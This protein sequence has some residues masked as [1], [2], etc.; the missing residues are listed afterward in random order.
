MITISNSVITA[1]ISEMGAELKSLR[2]DGFEYIW[3][4][5][6]QVWEDSA[7]VLFPIVGSLK[8]D[9]YKFEGREYKLTHHGFASKKEFSVKKKSDTAVTLLLC[10]DSETFKCYPFKFELRVTFTLKDT[11]LEICYKVKNRGKNTMYFSLG[12]HEAYATPE[13]VEDYDIIFDEKE[14][15]ETIL[16]NGGLL[17]DNK[18]LIA[19]NTNVM[20]LYDKYFIL[21]TL[22]FEGLKSKQCI[23]RNRKTER[24]VK[25][26]FPDSDYIAFWHYP[27]SSYLCIEPWSGLPDNQNSDYDITKKDGIITLKEAEEYRNIHKI[28]V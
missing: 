19:K 28:T 22:L 24:T 8:D 4:G 10:D 1:E 26:D 21:D 27:S 5:D 3:K 14:N 16:L 13:G 2:K 23:L 20:P 11:T 9:K 25:I 17:Q 15:L 12:S 6:P 18:M 7:P